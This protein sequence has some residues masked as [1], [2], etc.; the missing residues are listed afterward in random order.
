MRVDVRH[1]FVS[2]ALSG[3]SITGQLPDSALDGAQ[4]VLIVIVGLR[5]GS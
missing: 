4:V 2:E 1:K 3:G 5:D